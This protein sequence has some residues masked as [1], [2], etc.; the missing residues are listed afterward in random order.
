MITG[1][2]GTS[3]SHLGR[4]WGPFA[5]VVFAY[6]YMDA[7]VKPGGW[8]NWGKAENERTACFYEYKYVVFNACRLIVTQYHA[9]YNFERQ[10][11][12]EWEHRRM[13]RSPDRRLIF[14]V[15]VFWAR[16]LLDEKG[17]LGE[18]ISR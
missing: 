1:S 5:R 13:P 7:C 15:Q 16:E 11:Y 4:P 3:Y 12:D 6:T 14:L 10:L 18:R 8:D 2:G 9:Y 17:M